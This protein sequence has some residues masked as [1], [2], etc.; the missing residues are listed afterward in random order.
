MSPIALKNNQNSAK[1]TKNRNSFISTTNPE[2][3]PL[4]SSL[5]NLTRGADSAKEK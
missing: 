4:K 2:T 5:I 3:N 1:S